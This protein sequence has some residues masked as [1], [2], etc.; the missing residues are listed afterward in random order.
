MDTD[1]PE[2]KLK[3]PM[4]EIETLKSERQRILNNMHDQVRS[5][6]VTGTKLVFAP[7]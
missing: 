5:Q 2:E 7:S 3:R 1:R 6:Q 4:E